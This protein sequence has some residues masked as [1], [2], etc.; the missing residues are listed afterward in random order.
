[1]PLDIDLL[2]AWGATYKKVAQGEIIFN[3]GNHCSFYYQLV[4][5]SVKWVN[6][7]EDGREFI[8]TIIEPGECF[9]IMPLFDDE[10]YAASAVAEKDSI[11]LRLHKPVFLDLLTESTDLHFKFSRLLAEQIRFKLLLLKTISCEDPHICISTLLAYLKK[12]KKNICKDCNQLKLTR[13]QI[14][15]MTGLR[16]E[17]VIRTM[18]AMH[19]GGEL[20]IT[21]GKVFCMYD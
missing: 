7:N 1:M 20:L 19:D 5:G 3:E 11:L 8:Q 17:T 6:V 12:H 18:R 15:S 13:Q 10:P 21:K 16:V 2:L 14:A 4:S 9:G